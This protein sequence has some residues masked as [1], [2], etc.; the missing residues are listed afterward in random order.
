M[1]ADIL[2]FTPDWI[3]AHDDLSDRDAS[4]HTGDHVA[5]ALSDELSVG[6]GYSFLGVQFVCSFHT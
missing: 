1:M 4:A 2:V 3:L 6:R 5:D